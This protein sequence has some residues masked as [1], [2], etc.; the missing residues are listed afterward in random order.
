MEL[1]LFVNFAIFA[2]FGALG[3]VFFKA[4]IHSVLSLIVTL[5]AVAGLYSLLL[6]KTLFLIQIVVYGGAIMVLSVFVLMFFN[7]RESG[8]IKFSPKTLFLSL[9]VIGIFVILIE[10]ITK[11]SSDFP[12][13][14]AKFGEM[15]SLGL[16]LFNNYV[17]SFEAI[18]LLL[19]AALIGIV[20]INRGNKNG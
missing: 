1:F 19:T 16:Y 2:V 13:A 7:S 9:P 8:F 17:L 4:P 12:V 14:D 20:A 3:L 6:A 11:F 10:E 5:I 15:Q 18:S